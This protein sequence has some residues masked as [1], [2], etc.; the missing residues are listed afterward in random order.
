MA[1]FGKSIA[2]RSAFIAAG[3]SLGTWLGQFAGKCLARDDCTLDTPMLFIYWAA[4]FLLVWL[5]VGAALWGLERHRRSVEA[6]RP[7]Q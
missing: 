5:V 4:T 3:V 2:A 6:A 1:V 7:R